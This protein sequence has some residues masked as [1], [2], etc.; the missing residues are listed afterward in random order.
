MQYEIIVCGG[1]IVGMSTALSLARQGIKVAILAPEYDP[2]APTSGDDYHARIYAISGASQVLLEQLGVWKKIPTAR[3]QAVERMEI[4][5][6]AG[7]ELVLD[8]WQA[9]RK[10]L[11]W[12]MESGQ[13]EYVLK[14]ALSYLQVPWIDDKV[15]AYELGTIHTEKGQT[16]K[17]Q[18]CIGAD[19]ANSTLRELA[20]LA[21]TKRMYGDIGLVVQ[22]DCERHHRN[23]AYQWF[24]T[25]GIL[26]FLPL[27]D[28]SVGHQVSMVWSLR[29]PLAEPWL[30]KTPEEVAAQLPLQLEAISNGAL[31]KMHVRST[32]KGFPLTLQETQL[33]GNGV[34]LMGDA[35]HRLHPL[36]GQG[37]NL[38]LGDV[39]DLARILRDKESFR[40]FG[41]ERILARYRQ[42]RQ[43]DI[44]AMKVVTDN[45]HKLFA[46]HGAGI[47]QLRNVGLNVVQRMPWVKRQLIK[48]AVGV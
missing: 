37:L 30:E 36:A 43:P 22:L 20:G 16:L 31:G 8:A 3:Y 44:L 14:E 18:L 25:D 47:S 48:A 2:F 9:N 32:L 15:A 26:A 5:G 46:A 41:D 42:A 39:S 10:E 13:I 38:G 6:D 1:G 28:T 21:H 23:T 40:S 7:G 29:T 12:I 33:A 35:A 17:A 27:P 45:L 4:H 19:G 34:V 11:T 24:R